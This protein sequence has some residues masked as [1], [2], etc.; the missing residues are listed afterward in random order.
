MGKKEWP[1]PEARSLPDDPIGAQVKAC[2]LLSDVVVA[3]LCEVF[4]QAGAEQP[5]QAVKARKQY[6]NLDD[7]TDP[8]VPHPEFGQYIGLKA[9]LKWKD[10]DPNRSLAG[11][12]VYWSAKAISKWSTKELALSA[13]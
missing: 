4:T 10:G 13:T 8:A 12:V 9:R 11:K 1:K 5:P 3:E 2:S 6:V 7:E